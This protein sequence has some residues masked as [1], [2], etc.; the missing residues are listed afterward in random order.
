MNIQQGKHK[1]NISVRVTGQKS[2][3]LQIFR[4]F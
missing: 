1:K 3:A 4:K 2:K